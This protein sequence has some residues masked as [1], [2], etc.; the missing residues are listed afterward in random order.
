MKNILFATDLSVQGDR[1][2]DRAM[3]L[4]ADHKSELH[5]LHVIE[6]DP[7]RLESRTKSE[8][9]KA[10]RRLEREIENNFGSN[11]ITPK[12]YVVD[13]DPVSEIV[14]VAQDLNA[15]LII[16]GLSK[17]FTVETLFKGT[18]A[19]KVIA[20]SDF[21][22]LIVK[23]R[24]KQAYEKITVALD[25]SLPSRSAFEVALKFAPSARFTIIHGVESEQISEVELGHLRNQ[26]DGIAR[27]CVS[28]ML[29]VTTDQDLIFDIFAEAG[30]AGNILI[31]HVEQTKPDLVTFGRS[32]KSGFQALML[33]STA[34]ILIEHL[35]C[36][37]LVAPV[38]R[39]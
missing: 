33:G 9:G 3:I 8:I 21:P 26:I 19:D 11:D 31:E 5:I 15:D 34:R 7:H 6:K 38:V 27:A 2:L 24:P 18:T 14:N 30:Q 39:S 16:M 12:C 20:S 36:D 35:Q 22:I 10:V 23:S 1:A 29:E 28:D 17:E 25:L 32:N 4:A 37:L 13:G